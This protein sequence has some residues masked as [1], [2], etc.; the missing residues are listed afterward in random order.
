MADFCTFCAP[1]IGFP[2]DID[3]VEKFNNLT[4][5]Y[6]ID[7]FICEGCALVAIAKTE[8]GVIMFAGGEDKLWKTENEYYGKVSGLFVSKPL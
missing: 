4:P 7:D 1:N 8:Q 2:T 3:L 5:S 6:F